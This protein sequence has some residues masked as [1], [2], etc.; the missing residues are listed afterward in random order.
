MSEK[1]LIPGFKMVKSLPVIAMAWLDLEKVVLTLFF[2]PYKVVFD[3]DSKIV[4][5]R[6]AYWAIPLMLS[7]RFL[8]PLLVPLNSKGKGELLAHSSLAIDTIVSSL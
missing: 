7:R 1:P 2:G 8:M 4:T 6:K 5:Q 3:R